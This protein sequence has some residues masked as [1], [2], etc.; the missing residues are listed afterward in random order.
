MSEADFRA[1]IAEAEA[2]LEQKEARGGRIWRTVALTVGLTMVSACYGA[3][4]PRPAPPAADDAALH[5]AAPT[6]QQNNAAADES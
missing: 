1:A 3:P 2:A 5:Q 6:A 4:P